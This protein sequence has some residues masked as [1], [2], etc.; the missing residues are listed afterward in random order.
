MCDGSLYRQEHRFNRGRIKISQVPG[1][2]VKKEAASVVSEKKMIGNGRLQLLLFNKAK[3]GSPVR[4]LFVDFG[5][6]ARETRHTLLVSKRTGNDPIVTIC[7]SVMS[8]C[9][10][11]EAEVIKPGARNKIQPYSTAEKKKKEPGYGCDPK[12]KD[13]KV[14][15][16]LYTSV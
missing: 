16:I 6:S 7:D 15:P 8:D 10:M 13:E 3:V 1:D 14:L 9:D 12:Q 4:T 5:K 11:A 2:Q